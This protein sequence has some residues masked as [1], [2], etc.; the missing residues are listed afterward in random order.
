[1]DKI[2]IDAGGGEERE[3]EEVGFVKVESSDV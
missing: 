2:D 3:R 1:M